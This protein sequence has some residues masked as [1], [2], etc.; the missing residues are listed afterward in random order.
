MTG[1]GLGLLRTRTS[2]VPPVRAGGVFAIQ[3]VTREQLDL[4][5]APLV[6]L[7]QKKERPTLA[8]RPNYNYEKRQKEMKRE[9]KKQQKLEERRARKAA[10]AGTA[11]ATGDAEAAA[12]DGESEETVEVA[13]QDEVT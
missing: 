11:G 3:I 6:R 4:R 9:K 10:E 7:F 2:E 8:R 13:A 5:R 12:V 1:A